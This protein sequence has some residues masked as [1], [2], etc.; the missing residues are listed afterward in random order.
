M[1]V[2]LKVTRTL[3]LTT[4]ETCWVQVPDDWAEYD[5]ADFN[6]L[7]DEYVAAEGPQIDEAI[8]DVIDVSSWEPDE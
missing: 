6:D 5:V 1:T 2:P 4:S 7:V 3:T 8:I